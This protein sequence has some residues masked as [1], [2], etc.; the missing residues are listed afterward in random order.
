MKSLFSRLLISLLSVFLLLVLAI[1]LAVQAGFTAS[2]QRW[3]L[4]KQKELESVA[5]AILE[6]PE[7]VAGLDIPTDIPFAVY[8]AEGLMVYSNR[9]MMMEPRGRGM[10]PP[11]QRGNGGG[12]PG[13]GFPPGGGPQPDP[14]L[15]PGIGIGGGGFG[16]SIRDLPEPQRSQLQRLVKNGETVG[17]FSGIQRFRNDSA[18]K[19][20]L[21]TLRSILL[22]SVLIAS[23]AAVILSLVFSRSLARPAQTLADGI[24]GLA[25]GNYS[26]VIEERG[27]TEIAGIARAANTLR[28]QLVREGQIRARWAQDIAHDLRT[29]LSALKAQLE[30]IRDGVFSADTPRMDRILAELRRMEQ[31]V[32]DL[33]ELERLED[34][35]TKITREEIDLHELI[36]GI[37]QLFAGETVKKGI[38]VEGLE[39]LRG[40]KLPGDRGLLT[41]A[42]SNIVANGVK[43]AERDGTI[44]FSCEDTGKEL[45]LAV[46]NT[47]PEIPPEEL[48]KVFDRL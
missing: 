14:G 23:V 16:G 25:A 36:S 1:A 18:N 19:A 2:E 30:G 46:W 37:V 28:N 13:S 32:S 17:Y 4:E 7:S 5:L 41:R 21:D 31:L 35:E 12:E 33:G 6:D 9:G 27:T 26:A 44:G 34:P 20:F 11:G 38:S 47:G 40:R 45:R 39:S 8:D 10:G 3:A 42:V 24:R 48:P 43:Y 29:P 15:M 22:F